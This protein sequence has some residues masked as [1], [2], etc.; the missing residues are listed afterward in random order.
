MEF[1]S[2]LWMPIVGSAVI[3]FIGSFITHMVLPLHANEFKKLPDEDKM[4]DAVSKIPAEL[5]CF[6]RPDDMKQM[7]SPEFVAKAQKG[8]NGLL[9]VHPGP[10]NMGQN[11]L[12]TFL[13]YI[14]VG[15][16]V[17]YIGWH[18]IGPNSSYLFRF[19]ICGAVAFA[20]HGLGW[21]SFFI[22]YRYGRL[23]PNFVDSLVYALLT[24]GT[25]AWLWPKA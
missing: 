1:L 11:L 3:V 6:P 8:P 10:V 12:L 25:F 7:S 13:F 17:A 23:W 16:F 21:M 2:A 18:A 20:A 22:W 5:Y 14:L 19:R 24:A 4:L 15:V 9:I